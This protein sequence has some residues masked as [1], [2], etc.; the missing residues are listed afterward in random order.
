L[1]RFLTV[2]HS[3][4]NYLLLLDRNGRVLQANDTALRVAGFPS[5]EIGREIWSSSWWADQRSK[6]SLRHLVARAGE[7]ELVRAQAAIR[8]DPGGRVDLSLKRS[9]FVEGSEPYLLLEARDISE[10]LEQ[11][12][13]L[14]HSER[15]R[16]LGQL[17]SGIAH[18]FNNLLLLIAANA[19]LLCQDGSGD[20]HNGAVGK[21]LLESVRQARELTHRLLSFTGRQQLSPQI[22]DLTEV[23]RSTVELARK[24]L[25]DTVTL[26]LRAEASVRASVDARYLEL[27]LLNLILNA[28][29]AAAPVVSIDVS[30]EMVHP[31]EADRLGVRP[32]PYASVIVS[33]T[34]TGM[35]P[36]VTAKAFE[37]FLR[38]SQ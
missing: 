30:P 31:E 11:Q 28:R 18:E 36:E 34:G 35:K 25:P 19:E 17:V 3:A 23:A 4:F 13:R 15:L 7:G 26:E 38:R 2:F 1:E 14:Q 27:A 12:D 21:K 29:D 16:A 37:P 22:V 6:E 9:T 8:G 5:Q 33:D 20:R 24:V 32:G 10:L